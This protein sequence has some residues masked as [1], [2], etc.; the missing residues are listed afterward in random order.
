MPFFILFATVTQFKKK[1]KKNWILKGFLI[2]FWRVH[3]PG[4]QFAYIR[5]PLCL[6]VWAF[7]QR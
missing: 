5:P 6:I 2:K 4:V 3:N 1:N 7:A